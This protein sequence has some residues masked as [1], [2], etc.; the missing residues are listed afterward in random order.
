MTFIGPLADRQ[1]IRERFETYSDAVIRKDLD[2]YLACW[3][4]DCRRTGA[5]GEC[6]GKDGLRT[7]W[8]EIFQTVEQM[9]FFTQP[10]SLVVADDRASA[11]SY[12]LEL[13]KLGDGSTRQLV[14]EYDDKLVRVGGD[15]L[16]AHRHYRVAMT[17]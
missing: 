12:C 7:H 11:R 5:G 6:D 3:A 16:F 8:H 15:W 17:F 2:T 9:A 1:L 13:M 4:D 14:G 10:A